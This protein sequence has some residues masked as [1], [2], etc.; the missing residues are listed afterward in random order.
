VSPEGSSPQRGGP[1]REIE[2]WW[3]IETTAESSAL[4]TQMSMNT[5]QEIR[6]H[7][8]AAGVTA[9]ARGEALEAD[10]QRKMKLWGVVEAF[11]DGYVTFSTHIRKGPCLTVQPHARQL[12]D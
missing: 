4:T 2:F 7:P 10:V 11:K 5:K 12:A 6:E 9:P 8:S 1:A 3:T